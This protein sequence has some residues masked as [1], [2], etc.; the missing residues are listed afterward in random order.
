MAFLRGTLRTIEREDHER[1]DADVDLGRAEGRRLA[2]HDEVAGQR[3]PE[4]P[5]QAVAVD[6]A[7][8]GLAQLADE[9]EQPREALGG[10]VLVHERHVGGEAG[11]VAARAEG[12]LVRGGEHDAAHGVVVARG[13]EGGDEVAQQLVG[14]RVARVG[15]VHGDG[16][17]AASATS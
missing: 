15:L 2:G 3:Q 4:R 11:E 13:L 10:D 16:G 14:Q 9:R 1:E 5:G 8:H 12:R 7:D 6:R 17:H